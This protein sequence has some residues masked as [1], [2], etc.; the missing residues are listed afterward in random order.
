MIVTFSGTSATGYAAFLAD[1]ATR[2]IIL[3]DGN[4]DQN[5][6]IFTLHGEDEAYPYPGG[7]LSDTSRFRGGDS[8]RGLTGV[9]HRAFDGWRIQPVAERFDYTFTADNP[10]PTAPA[11]VGGA[12]APSHDISRIYGLG[13]TE[14]TSPT[15]FSPDACTTRR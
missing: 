7:G 4:D 12:S 15:T 1:L 8:I 6:A 13:M 10:W 5:D 9:M 14:G 3:D 2:R 11:E